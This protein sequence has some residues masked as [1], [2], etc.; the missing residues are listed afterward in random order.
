M[1]RRRKL[2]RD[3]QHGYHT[4]LLR[5]D[6][7]TVF[8]R[9]GQLAVH[10]LQA[11]QVDLELMRRSLVSELIIDAQIQ[12]HIRHGGRLMAVEDGKRASEGLSGHHH[13]LLELQ[14]DGSTHIAGL[15]IQSF[16]QQLV[17]CIIHLCGRGITT[18]DSHLLACGYLLH[19][20]H[21]RIRMH[22]IGRHV[23]YTMHVV[24]GIVHTLN[25]LCPEVIR[26]SGRTICTQHILIQCAVNRQFPC[27]K[28]ICHLAVTHVC[29]Q[30]RF[31]IQT[32][33]FLAVDDLVMRHFRSPFESSQVC[34]FSIILIRILSVVLAIT[35]GNT[36]C[37]LSRMLARRHEIFQTI[38]DVLQFAFRTRCCFNL[39]RRL[40]RVIVQ[41]I[42]YRIVYNV[43]HI[44][45]HFIHK[46]IVTCSLLYLIH[47]RFCSNLQSSQSGTEDIIGL[48]IV[49]THC[50]INIGDGF[51]LIQYITYWCEGQ[52]ALDSFQQE[53]V[54]AGFASFIDIGIRRIYMLIIVIIWS[55]N[56]STGTIDRP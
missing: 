29:L 54:L 36:G 47:D 53:L 49:L 52:S 35:C 26:Q 19:V 23:S 27:G 28:Q 5:T 51:Q 50:R 6:R 21:S 38:H 45:D 1:C 3:E 16:I 8:S 43:Y 12:M 20:E 37:I 40:I 31:E 2:G 14:G 34:R 11:L 44:I 15:V 33:I 9:H 56:R 17:F 4:G 22:K 30:L 7:P 25:Q 13:L 42:V 48:V 55:A 41:H 46:V 18:F 24:I 32:H 39:C 10:A